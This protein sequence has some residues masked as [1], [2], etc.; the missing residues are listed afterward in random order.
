MGWNYE[1]REIL[2]VYSHRD[3]KLP[4]VYIAITSTELPGNKAF[5]LLRNVQA[6]VHPHSGYLLVVG[7]LQDTCGGK[8][9]ALVS[10]IESV[11]YSH[12][13]DDR[14]GRCSDRCSSCSLM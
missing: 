6:E 4:L 1:G 9:E 13:P 2:C 5:E 8:I 10:K 12:S 7:S 11:A 3:E 14:G